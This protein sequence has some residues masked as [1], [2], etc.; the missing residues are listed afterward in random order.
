MLTN[1]KGRIAVAK[2]L[3]LHCIH[4][5]AWN[6]SYHNAIMACL[7]L[8]S[9]FQHSRVFDIWLIAA[10]FPIQGYVLISS[11]KPFF[12]STGLEIRRKRRDAEHWKRL[13]LKK[14]DLI[15]QHWLCSQEEPKEDRD[16]MWMRKGIGAPNWRFSGSTRRQWIVWKLGPTLCKVGL[17]FLC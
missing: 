13:L 8:S 5:C 7:L 9:V 6:R 4:I 12:D 14:S 17:H 1:D 16:W 2:Y 3:C 10:R 15:A 11:P